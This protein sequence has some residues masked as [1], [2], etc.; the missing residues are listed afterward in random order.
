MTLTK[1]ETKLAIFA[2]GWVWVGF[3]PAVVLTWGA[4]L[5]ESFEGEP[6]SPKEK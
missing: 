3:W 6:T 2:L 1:G 5:L 4:D